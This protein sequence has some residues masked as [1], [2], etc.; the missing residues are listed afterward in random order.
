MH[1][2]ILRAFAAQ[3][4]MLQWYSWGTILGFLVALAATVWIFADAQRSGQDATIWKSVAAVAVV[5]SVPALLAR[6]HRGFAIEMEASLALLAYLSMAATALAAVAAVAFVAGRGSGPTCPICNQPQ[7]PGWTTCPYHQTATAAAGGTGFSIPI[8]EAGVA[9]GRTYA[10]E[11]ELRSSSD[12]GPRET[13]VGQQNRGSGSGYGDSS[14][15]YRGTRILKKDQEA[16]ALAFL[17]IM[18]GPYFSNVLPLND[19]ITR[20]GR[21]GNNLDHILDDESV[22]GLHASIRY[23]DGKF[24]VTDMDSA[25]GTFVNGER[26]LQQVLSSHDVLTIGETSL[27]FFQAPPELTR[28]ATRPMKAAEP[29]VRPGPAGAD[30]A[31]HPADEGRG[32]ARSWLD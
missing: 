11:G 17:A 20:I 7:Q 3:P 22:S 21:D 8:T 26:I 13:L 15:P 32:P 23:Q 29:D 27:M 12:S 28:P 24:Q 2:I 10:G 31:R 14:V 25:N 30:Q 9:P 4:I 5:L 1:D 19:G 18:S 16:R 6:V